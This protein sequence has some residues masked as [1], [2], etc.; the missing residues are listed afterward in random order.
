MESLE[1]L[2][3]D[4]PSLRRYADLARGTYLRLRGQTREAMELFEQLLREPAGR[5]SGT[6]AAV[7]SLAFLLNQT[8]EPARA[9]QITGQ[10]LTAWGPEDRAFVRVTLWAQIQ[11]A[12]ATAA[13]GHS[14]EAAQLLDEW[15]EEHSP[16]RGPVTL[17][18]LHEARARVAFSSGDSEGFERHRAH[19]A[20]WLRPTGN[21]WLIA[22][23]ERLGTDAQRDSRPPQSSRPAIHMDTARS[24]LSE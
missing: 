7:A 15:I 24:G 8:G 19:M 2:G 3:S 13:L 20:R 23:C 5:F 4:V 18:L 16:G 1:R 12:M 10:L 17:G 22:L 6:A 21:P 14:A 9:R 11:H